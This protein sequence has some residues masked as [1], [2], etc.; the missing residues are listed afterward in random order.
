[1]GSALQFRIAAAQRSAAWRR[2][3]SCVARCGSLRQDD[4]K[5]GLL[6]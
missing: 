5:N 2:A 3:E 4:L 1:M 6:E